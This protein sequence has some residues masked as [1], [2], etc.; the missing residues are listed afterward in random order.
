[1]NQALVSGITGAA[2]IWN[3]LMRKV[4][5]GK[6][7]IWPKQPEGII[8]AQICA[9]SGLLPPNPDPDASDKG[10]PTRFEY[11]IKGTV[12]NE[13]ESL[14]QAVIIDKST[15]DIAA[16]GKTD[17]VEPQEHQVL[18]DQTGAMWCLDCQHPGDGQIQL[19]K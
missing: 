7:D 16:P 19:L 9:V 8:G 12:P 15:G 10:C 4:L 5:E 11:F 6:P 1:M 3:K 18:K 13:R 2:P 14:K 17:N